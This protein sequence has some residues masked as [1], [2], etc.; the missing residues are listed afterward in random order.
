MTVS[1]R[2]FSILEKVAAT[3]AVM[4]VL[5][6]VQEAKPDAAPSIVWRAARLAVGAKLSKLLDR[7]VDGLTANQV[8]TLHALECADTLLVSF[9]AIYGDDETTRALEPD[10]R[11]VLEEMAAKRKA[12]AKASADKRKAKKVAE[13]AKPVAAKDRKQLE[14]AA[15]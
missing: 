12:A 7:P 1:N 11:L 6:R 3:R 14:F 8:A 2:P 15:A 9:G 10:E 13:A 5:K 4:S